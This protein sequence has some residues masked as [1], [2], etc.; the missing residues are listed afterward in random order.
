SP[1][2]VM[3]GTDP[4]GGGSGC[5][6]GSNDGASCM[7]AK[8][9]TV[10]SALSMRVH[11]GAVSVTSATSAQPARV[12]SVTRRA[13]VGARPFESLEVANLN[14]LH[15]LADLRRAVVPHDV[16]HLCFAA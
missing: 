7:N 10:A 16:S 8:I 12:R 15:L 9:G 1:L 6:Y 5:S 13:L 4:G 3:K 14:L 11:A 2:P